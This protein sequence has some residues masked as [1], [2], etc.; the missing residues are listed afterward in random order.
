MRQFLRGIK[1]LI[2]YAP[3][4]WRDRDFDYGYLLEMLIF[5]LDRMAKWFDR[6]VSEDCEERGAEMREVR[7]LLE[8][9]LEDNY[10]E[11]LYAT[12]EE[13][14]GK[15]VC[16]SCGTRKLC[17]KCFPNYGKDGSVIGW[18]MRRVHEKADAEGRE[19]E[20]RNARLEIFYTADRLKIVDVKDAFAIIGERLLWWWD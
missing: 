16:P 10:C 20:A 14:Y 6:G 8:R 3:L 4:I 18:G 11:T 15:L 17:C 5:K 19:V 13:A 1:N 12:H 7:A 2:D 9:V